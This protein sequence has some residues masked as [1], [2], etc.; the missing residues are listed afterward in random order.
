MVP[1][2]SRDATLIASEVASPPPRADSCNNSPFSL[3][4]LRQP[5]F[6]MQSLR[7]YFDQIEEH[8]PFKP[9]KWDRKYKI[10][11][12]CLVIVFV[13]MAIVGFALHDKVTLIP[14]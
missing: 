5:G 10:A 12:L 7:H 4:T 13:I 1:T 2:A 11:F 9:S 3:P 8:L 14:L 6:R